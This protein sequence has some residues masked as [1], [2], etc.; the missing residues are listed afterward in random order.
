MPPYNSTVVDRLLAS[1]LVI[2]GKTNLDE[3]AMGSSTETSAFGPTRNPWGLGRIP[4]GS[5]GGFAAAL[6]DAG[7]P[8][9]A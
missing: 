6:A 8:P 9:A 3:F 2:L 7:L 4:G 5:G 1:D